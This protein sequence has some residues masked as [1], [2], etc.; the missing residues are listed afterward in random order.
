MNIQ[1]AEV[2]LTDIAIKEVHSCGS[3]ED[4]GP[5]L[6]NVKVKVTSGYSCKAKAL[7][8]FTEKNNFWK[9]IVSKNI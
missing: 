7:H 2:M 1:Q 9:N 3:R 5:V 4:G 8:I 6:F